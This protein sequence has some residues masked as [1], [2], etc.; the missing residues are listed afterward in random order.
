MNTTAFEAFPRL[1][2]AMEQ[3]EKY[4]PLL[5]FLEAIPFTEVDIWLPHLIDKN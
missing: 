1:V 2:S 4:N 3:D 5:T